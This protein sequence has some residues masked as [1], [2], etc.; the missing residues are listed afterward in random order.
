MQIFNF[1]VRIMKE[2]L[3]IENNIY[4]QIHTVVS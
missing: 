3:F 4:L 2:N 1:C